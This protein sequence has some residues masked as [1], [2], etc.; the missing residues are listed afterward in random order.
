MMATR[1][2]AQQSNSQ[3]VMRV[4]KERGGDE[5]TLEIPKLHVGEGRKYCYHVRFSG[6]SGLA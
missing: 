3:D 1:T 4:Y 5:V 2:R 6:Q